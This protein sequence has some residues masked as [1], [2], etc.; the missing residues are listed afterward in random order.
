MRG[1]AGIIQPS[2]FVAGSSSSVWPPRQGSQAPA[3]YGRGRNGASS[4][5]GPQNRIYALVGRQDQESSPDVVTVILSVSSYD[6]YAFID[7]GSTLS[8]VTPLVASRFGI[9]LELIEPFEVSTPVGDPVIARR[10]KDGSVPVSRGAS[11]GVESLYDFVLVSMTMLS[12]LI[13]PPAFSQSLGLTCE[14]MQYYD[15]LSF[16]RTGQVAYKLEFPMELGIVHLIFHV[17][18]LRKCLGYSSQVTPIEDIQVIE[19]LSYEEISVA[20]LDPRVR[21][22]RTKKVASVKVL[23]R[24]NKVEEMTWEAKEDMKSR[25]PH[26]FHTM[27]GNVEVT[28]TGTN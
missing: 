6:V 15:K 14:H 24:N 22:L 12:S 5:S 11:S 7:L 19:D 26:M 21:K 17:S 8:Y 16:W 4:S 3:G 9:E 20:I 13:F 18:M 1:G 23:W 2:R 27:G 28:A 25:Y 10:I